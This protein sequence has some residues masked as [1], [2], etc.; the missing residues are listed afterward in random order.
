[1]PMN[2]AAPV[3]TTITEAPPS[4][5]EVRTL[6]QRPAAGH[7]RWG[8]VGSPDP[9][10]GRTA[11]RRSRSAPVIAVGGLTH[12]AVLAVGAWRQRD[13]S[14]DDRDVRGEDDR[15]RVAARSGG[16]GRGGARP[17]PGRLGR[18]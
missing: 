17:G 3:T 5:L 7:R 8:E 6:V 18:G 10:S 4:R 13:R 12:L 14:V 15:A 1:D 9:R 16:G 2:P 11:H